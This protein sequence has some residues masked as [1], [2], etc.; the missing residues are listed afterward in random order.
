M[1][2]GEEEV[3]KCRCHSHNGLL[4]SGSSEEL[5]EQ[6]SLEGLARRRDHAYIDSKVSVSGLRRDEVFVDDLLEEQYRRFH[7]A[8]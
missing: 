1:E 4:F 6:L 5:A 7:S 3:M 8:P 2:D